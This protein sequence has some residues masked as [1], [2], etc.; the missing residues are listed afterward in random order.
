MQRDFWSMGNE[1]GYGE[2]FEEAGR[3]IREYDPT[4]LL[5]Y[6][7]SV[8]ESAGYKNDLSM[9]DVMSRMYPPAEWVKEY[10]EDRRM[11]KPLILCEFVHAM[12][13]GPGDIEDYMEL[14]NAQDKFCGGFVWEW[15]DHATWEGKAA[16]GRDI[17]HYGGDAGEFPP[18]ATSVWTAWSIRTGGRI[19][20]CGSGKTP[21]APCARSWRI[22]LKAEFFCAICRIF[23]ICPIR[24]NSAMKS[25]GTGSFWPKAGS[26]IC[27][28]SLMK[29]PG[30]SFGAGEIRRG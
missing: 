21:S 8:W 7:G 16:D 4:R 30:L 28:Q 11:K 9:L 29:R 24:W 27:A 22:F 14:M 6:E 23:R 20:A 17:Y 13:N 2:N 10:C 5:H 3:W 1:S 26:G 18:T 19:R 12:G 15:C 25:N